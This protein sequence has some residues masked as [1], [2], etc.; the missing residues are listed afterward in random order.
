LNIGIRDTASLNSCSKTSY[1]GFTRNKNQIPLASNRSEN[2]AIE[3]AKKNRERFE[4]EVLKKGDTL[5]Q[6]LARS[7]LFLIQKQIKMVAKPNRTCQFI[8]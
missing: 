8:I 3:K 2:E 5:K 6:L 1:R 4:P 7:R